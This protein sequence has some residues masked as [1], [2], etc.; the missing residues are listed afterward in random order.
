[1]FLGQNLNENLS[2]KFHMLKVIKK[3]SGQ[4]SYI[5]IIFKLQFYSNTENLIQIIYFLKVTVCL[6]SQFGT[7][8]TKLQ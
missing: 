8:K 7:M 1:M 5:G 3:C 2:W 4:W 6:A